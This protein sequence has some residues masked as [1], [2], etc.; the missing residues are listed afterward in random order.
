[1]KKQQTDTDTRKDTHT[2]KTI[3]R[4]VMRNKTKKIACMTHYS[5]PHLV[6]TKTMEV[7][8]WMKKP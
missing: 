6:L 1:M 7:F 8:Q 5:S 4:N 3:N 2:H